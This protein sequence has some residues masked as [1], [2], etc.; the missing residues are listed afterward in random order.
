MGVFKTIR[1]Q[2]IIASSCVA[3][4][5]VILISHRL[6][7]YLTYTSASIKDDDIFDSDQVQQYP[8]GWTLDEDQGFI[9][10]IR[11][12]WLVKPSPRA[13]SERKKTRAKLGP[14][15]KTDFSQY[16]QPIFIDKQLK[17]IENGFFVECGA[18]NGIQM[19][20]TFFFEEVRNW[21]G[22][23]IE[24]SQSLFKKLL[25]S[26][27]NAYMINACLNT[28]TSSDQV[29]FLYGGVALGGIKDKVSNAYVNIQSKTHVFYMYNTTKLSIRVDIK[30]GNANITPFISPLFM[31][32]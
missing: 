30:K 16:R 27:R 10:Y 1:Q 14:K 23:L 7:V 25:L 17:E 31:P 2:A 18:Y 3:I 20:N 11:R 21:T 13:V 12:R 6:H 26:G 9:R 15:R 8:K 4:L 19:S 5:I 24:G 32:D 22:L 28:E 29:T